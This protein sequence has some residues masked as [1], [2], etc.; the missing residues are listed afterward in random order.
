MFFFALNLNCQAHDDD[1]CKCALDH[2]EPQKNCAQQ[3]GDILVASV[4][5]EGKL[6]NS[7]RTDEMKDWKF[8]YYHCP[9]HQQQFQIGHLHAA[10]EIAAD[11]HGLQHVS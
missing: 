11:F 7:Y 2:G 9:L 10:A 8:A 1:L 4:V 3:P 5:A 6:G